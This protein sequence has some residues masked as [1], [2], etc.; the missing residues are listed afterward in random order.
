M[1]YRAPLLVPGRGLGTLPLFL[2]RT[3]ITLFA[4][5]GSAWCP[6]TYAIR[7]APSTSLCTTGDVS[8]GFAFLEPNHIVSFG[9]ELNLSAAILSW[10][11]PFRYR[12]GYAV[13]ALG[14]EFVPG[15]QKPLL[16]FTVGGS[17]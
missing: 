11:S 14:R 10:D 12:L 16:Y 8:G 15:D 3:S 6:G 1:E 5:A 4:D 9:G 2:D 13:P 17:F 7:P